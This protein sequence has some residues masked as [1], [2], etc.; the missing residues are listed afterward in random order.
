M[1]IKERN[2]SID[3][4]KG[5]AIMSVLLLHNNI[6]VP[7]KIAWIG[8]AV[9]LFLLITA[10]LTYSSFQSGKTLQT[11]YS[12][13]TFS[14]ML[15]RIFLPFFFVVLAQCAISFFLLDNFSLFSTISGGGMGRGSYYPWI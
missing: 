4:I 12:L 2:N 7:F 14:K 1:M 11:Y 3:F 6:P 13:N 9:P 8:Q 10:S 15:K 5:V